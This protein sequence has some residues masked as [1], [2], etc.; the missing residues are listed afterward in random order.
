MAGPEKNERRGRKR[1]VIRMYGNNNNVYIGDNITIYKH[2]NVE[3]IRQERWGSGVINMY[4]KN[5]NLCIGNDITIHQNQRASDQAAKVEAEAIPSQPEATMDMVVTQ[6]GRVVIDMYG[7][8]NL[9]IGKKVAMH[10]N[11]QASNQEAKVEAEVIPPQPEA[12]MDMV[13]TQKGRVVIDM[14]GK[15]NLCIRK[16]VAMHQNQQA[17]NQ[18]AKVE[19]EV[20][21]PQPEANMDMVV[22]QKGP[23]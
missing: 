11:Q 17:S 23:N 3:T 21:P 8:N 5:K 2:R 12:T 13:V 22:T 14:Y 10:Q 18:D 15:N 7:K 9:C 6:K 1:T 4:G 19:A 16:K 20:I